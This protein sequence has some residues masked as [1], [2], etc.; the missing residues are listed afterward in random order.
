MDAAKLKEILY[1]QYGI[2]NEEEF[3]AAVENYTGLN[4]GIFT[5][6][7]RKNGG[8]GEKETEVPVSA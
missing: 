3:N 7:L 4:I 2:K 5:M 1:K 6:P 8:N